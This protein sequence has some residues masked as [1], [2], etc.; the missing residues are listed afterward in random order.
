MGSHFPPLPFSSPTLLLALFRLSPLFFLS[1]APL[2]LDVESFKFSYGFWVTAVSSP[3]TV[4]G[5]AS[6][7]IKFSA[8]ALQPYDVAC[9]ICMVATI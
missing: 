4:W 9:D 1:S 8:R 2:L 5:T 6:A 3:N 7:E